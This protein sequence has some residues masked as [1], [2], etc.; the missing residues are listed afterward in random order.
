M[1]NNGIADLEVAHR[2]PDLGNP[3]G[4]FMPAGKREPNPYTLLHCSEL[5]LLHVEIGPTDPRGPNLDDHIRRRGDLR[6]PYR[7][8]L[9]IRVI[10]GQQGGFHTRRCAIS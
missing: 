2:R 6:I 5:A 9:E 3:A 1:K 8:D 7:R 4:C 10:F